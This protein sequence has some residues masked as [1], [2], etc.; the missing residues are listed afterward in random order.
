LARRANLCFLCLSPGHLARECDQP[1]AGAWECGCFLCTARQR[2][3]LLSPLVSGRRPSVGGCS[4]AERLSAAPFSGWFCTALQRVLS[5]S[6][7]SS[8]GGSLR[9]YSAVQ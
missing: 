7:R 8:A 2:L 5:L 9:R 6:P 3:V 1:G 4:G